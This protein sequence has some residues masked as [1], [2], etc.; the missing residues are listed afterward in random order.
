MTPEMMAA[1]RKAEGLFLTLLEAHKGPTSS[2][3]TSQYYAP[4]L[5]A[6]HH[7]AR[8]TGVDQAALTVALETL[9]ADG[10]VVVG[11]DKTANGSTREK[12]MAGGF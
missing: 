4:K 8:A 6:K 2:A 9:L 1:N 7:M 3:K 5:F 12:L 11:S 10:R